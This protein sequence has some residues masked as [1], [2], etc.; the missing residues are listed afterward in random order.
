MTQNVAQIGVEL[1]K[2][3]KPD[4]GSS[5][6]IGQVPKKPAI[7]LRQRAFIWLREPD[8]N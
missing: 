4:L 7:S 8:L 1:I 2:R 5:M 6:Q 3:F